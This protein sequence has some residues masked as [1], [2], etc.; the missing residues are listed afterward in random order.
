MDVIVHNQYSDIE[1]TSPE[2]FCN[3]EVYNEHSIDRM[4][5]V[6]MMKIGFRFDLEQGE[7]GGVMIYKV[8]RKGNVKSDHQPSTDT[9]S[10]EAIENTSKT[11]QLL[12][13]WK[14]ER[15]GEPRIRIMLVEH[16][17]E[18]VLREKLAQL[19]DK[20]NDVLSKE[21]DLFFKSNSIFKS[22]WLVCDNTVLEATYKVV[23][24]EGLGLNITISKGVKDM[25]TKS[26][27]WIDSRRQV[28]SLIVTYSY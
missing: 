7:S 4:S 14:I 6:A 5:D 8:Q 20:I 22:T 18:L 17:N 3:C 11:M 2:Y 1:L 27:L 26:A 21:Y 9:T 24:E 13:A 28:I 12:I 23:H 19:Y 16:D 25:Y 15:F 10:I